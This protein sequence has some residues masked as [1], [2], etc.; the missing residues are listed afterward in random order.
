MESL[1]LLI[2]HWLLN[3]EF[4]RLMSVIAFFIVMEFLF[5]FRNQ[6]VVAVC[7]KGHFLNC[8]TTA[9]LLRRTVIISMF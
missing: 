5:V 3:D 6:I 2:D 1:V 7:I 9:L 4:D 8:Q